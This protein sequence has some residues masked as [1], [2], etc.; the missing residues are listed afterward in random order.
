MRPL[1]AATLLSFCCT[2]SS[3]PIDKGNARPTTTEAAPIQDG[4]PM[5]TSSNCNATLDSLLR[6]D[7]AA[8]PGL[9]ADCTLDALGAR[10]EIDG[11]D[12]R[13]VLGQANEPAVY[14]GARVPGF[15]ETARIW[16]QG[17]TVKKLDLDLPELAD[18]AGLL[19]A[20]GE[21]EAKLDYYPSTVPMLRAKGAWV[22]ATR[23]ITLFMSKDG[24]N[25]V[26]F[27]VYPP[28][29]AADYAR[30]LFFT[31]PPRERP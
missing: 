8:M 31:E 3:P 25:V 16:H 4:P 22:Y 23:G 7:L 1:L 6:K 14:R 13:G 12:R 9:P 30:D 5:T 29:T 21:P 28:T 17:G 19:T 27:E 2:G 20:L 18:V 15:D 24:A 10:I 11:S 26:R